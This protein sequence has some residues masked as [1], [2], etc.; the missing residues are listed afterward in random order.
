MIVVM[1]IMLSWLSLHSYDCCHGYHCIAMIVVMAIMLSWP[2]LHS[3][4]CCHGY[5][6]VMAVA[7]IILVAGGGG[8]LDAVGWVHQG[9]LAD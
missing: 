3:Y 5:H 9:I 8:V 2:P 6:V 4:D 1:A 7:V